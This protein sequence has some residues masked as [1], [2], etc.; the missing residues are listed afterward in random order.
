[1]GISNCDNYINSHISEPDEALLWLERETNIRTNHARMLSGRA[2]GKL[3][4][5]LSKM[6]SPKRI[7]EIGTFTGYSAISLAKGLAEGGVL[8]TLE[9]NDELRYIIE[10]GFKRSG[11]DSII[12][13][14]I[15]DAKEIIPQLAGPYDLVFIDA[16][17]RE[18]VNYYNLV[19]DIVRPGGYIVA[20]N[21]LWDGKVW[22]DPMQNDAQTRG[23]AQFN[24]MVKNDRRVENVLLPIRD[25]INLIRKL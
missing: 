23:I 13:L 16:N 9:V 17:K 21:V 24:D 25:G 2:Q 18:Y 19:F 14:H 10:E 3:L 6:V 22:Q 1:M 8:D 4:E 12:K 5:I 20:D 15:G 11:M 7:L